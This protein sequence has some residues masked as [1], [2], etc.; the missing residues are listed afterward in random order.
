MIVDDGV[1]VTESGAIVLYL[2]RKSGKLIPRDLAGEAHRASR[3]LFVVTS[4]TE[5][6]FYQIELV[7]GDYQIC[8][9]F[10][11]C[12]RFT[13]SP[14]QRVR[15]DYEFGPGSAGWSR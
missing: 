3:P 5:H 8:T 4:D 15:L 9:T 6:G 10:Q 1:V 12:T 13:V 7:T 11:R 2:A 14:G